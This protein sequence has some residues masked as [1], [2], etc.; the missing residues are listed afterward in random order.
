MPEAL[1]DGAGWSG[2]RLPGLHR[3]RLGEQEP[4]PA[5][6]PAPPRRGSTPWLRGGRRREPG[7]E[8]GRPRPWVPA[9]LAPYLLPGS[10]AGRPPR[11]APCLFGT[12][13]AR[14]PPFPV[15]TEPGPMF[16]LATAA[17]ACGTASTKACRVGTRQ[18]GPAWGGVGGLGGRGGVDSPGSQAGGAGP[19]D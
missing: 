4:S 13:V 15:R 16:T 3:P 6:R 14:Q 12:P 18:R 8:G 11:P 17:W 5:L 1:R 2:K 7:S 10:R 9:A 19:G